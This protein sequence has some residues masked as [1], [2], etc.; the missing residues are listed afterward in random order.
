M[1]ITSPALVR[2]GIAPT[3]TFGC[4]LTSS[5]LCQISL[6]HDEGM[7]FGDGDQIIE[8]SPTIGD[9]F[10]PG[11]YESSADANHTRITSTPLSYFVRNLRQLTPYYLFAAITL[12][13]EPYIQREHGPLFGI[14]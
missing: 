4:L 12:G 3:V 9:L 1:Q 6:L 13:S 11:S 10:P 2:P 7:I 8:T 14:I 5:Y